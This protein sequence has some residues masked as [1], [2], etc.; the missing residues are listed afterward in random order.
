M[1]FTAQWLH[2]S[3]QHSISHGIKKEKDFTFSDD[4]DLGGQHLKTSKAVL[5]C[6]YNASKSLSPYKIMI[7]LYKIMMS[8]PPTH[9]YISRAT[10]VSGA[11]TL[12]GLQIQFPLMPAGS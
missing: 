6:V 7:S 11:L 12:A 10:H 1:I 9:V 3:L 2:V 5:M 8:Q 4:L